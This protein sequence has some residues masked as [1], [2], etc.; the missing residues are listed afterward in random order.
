[1]CV[2]L[3]P[4]PTAIVWAQWQSYGNNT[5]DTTAIGEGLRHQLMLEYLGSFFVI[6]CVITEENLYLLIINLFKLVIN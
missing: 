3:N 5:A 1:M 2:N 6:I 4:L